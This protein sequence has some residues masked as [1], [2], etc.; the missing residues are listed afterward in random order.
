MN[1]VKRECSTID[2]LKKQKAEKKDLTKLQTQMTSN[3][4]HNNIF[5][6]FSKETSFEIKNLE[7]S[8]IALKLECQDKFSK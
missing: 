2:M 7:K 3:Y 4:C 1:D 8:L 6:E 5:E